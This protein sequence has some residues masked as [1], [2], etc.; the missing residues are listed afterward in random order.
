MEKLPISVIIPLQ[1]HRRNFFENFC[2]PLIEANNP[3]QIIIVDGNGS[4]PQKR[5]W[6]LKQ[7]NQKYVFFCDDDKQIPKTFLSTLHNELIENKDKDIAYA[8]TNYI[9]IILHKEECPYPGN[10]QHTAN[11][12]SWDTLKTG[13]FIDT[14]SLIEKKYCTGFDEK[15]RRFQD[16]EMWIN[17]YKTYSKTGIYVPQTYFLSYLLDSGIT[18][19]NNP[20]EESMQYIRKKHSI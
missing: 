18:S 20:P 9:G 11:K 3:S 15:L 5:N 12:W 10:F 16:W 17:I 7:S 14:S 2:L 4:A 6:G 13:N 19:N 1:E 8:Y